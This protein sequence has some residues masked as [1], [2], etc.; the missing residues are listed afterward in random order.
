MN[1]SEKEKLKKL[2]KTRVSIYKLQIFTSKAYET[3]PFKNWY[4]KGKTSFHGSEV[5]L[6]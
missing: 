2:P 5:L 3:L 6:I 4:I 1:F